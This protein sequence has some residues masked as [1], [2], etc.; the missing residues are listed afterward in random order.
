MFKREGLKDNVY[1]TVKESHQCCHLC[2]C[3]CLSS[4]ELLSPTLTL[5]LLQA[6]EGQGPAAHSQ[7]QA[8]TDIQ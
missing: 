4:L 2:G 5:L 7:C 6:P 3:S 8:E 1:Q